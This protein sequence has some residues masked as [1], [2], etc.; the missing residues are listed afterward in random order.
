[1]FARHYLPITL[2]SLLT[3]CA[4]PADSRPNGPPPV[5]A[6]VATVERQPIRDVVAMVGALAAEES[7]M[8]RPEVEGVVG[9]VH[10]DEGQDVAAGALLLRLRAGSERARLAEAEA[11]LE[12]AKQEFERARSLA[13]KRTLS[14]AELDRAGAEVAVAQ[15]RLDLRRVQL[16]EKEVRAPF[17]GVLGARLVSV[18]D[19]VDRDTS[20]VQIDAVDPLRVLFTLPETA[21]GLG[22]VDLDLEVRVAAWPDEVFPGQVYFVAPTVDPRNRRVMVKGLVPNSERRLRPGMFANINVEIADV[23]D[24]VVVPEAAIAYDSQGAFVWRLRDG[25]IAERVGIELGIREGARVEVRAGIEAGERIVVAG[26]HKVTA[27]VVV[28]EAAGAA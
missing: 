11:Q 4:Q 25:N 13:A 1:M 27:G 17:D 14:R 16:A 15:A 18:G 21:L 26:T 20:I 7:V 5:Y 2:L 28:Q 3:A 23:P 24:A 6:G 12:L 8:I 9:E 19:R 10:F 22:Q